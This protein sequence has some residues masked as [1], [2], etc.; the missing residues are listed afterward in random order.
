[1]GAGVVGQGVKGLKEFLVRVQVLRLYRSTLRI[2][3][4]APLDSR[5]EVVS[6]VREEYRKYAEVSDPVTIKHL[7]SEG[8]RQRKML[9]EMI[10]MQTS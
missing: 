10:D 2:A 8:K 9:D 1:M 6:L 5:G 3:R 7:I 4:R